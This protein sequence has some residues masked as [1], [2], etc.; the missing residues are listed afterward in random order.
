MI[1]SSST[2]GTTGDKSSTKKLGSIQN[3]DNH[4]I[5]HSGNGPSQLPGSSNLLSSFLPSNNTNG[6]KNS[7]PNDSIA[8]ENLIE[9]NYNPNIKNYP[10]SQRN[11][12][13]QAAK[14]EAQNVISSLKDMQDH[15]DIRRNGHSQHYKQMAKRSSIKNSQS[16]SNEKNDRY[17][18]ML[19]NFNLLGVVTTPRILEQIAAGKANNDVMDYVHNVNGTGNDTS[20]LSTGTESSISSFIDPSFFSS[21][22]AMSNTLSKEIG[23]LNSTLYSYSKSYLGTM[24]YSGNGAVEGFSVNSLSS[25]SGNLDF[26]AELSA[27]TANSSSGGV[28]PYVFGEDMLKGQIPN[29]ELP[30]EIT[31]LDLSSVEAYLRKCGA[32]AERLNLS[33]IESNGSDD[34]KQDNA[35]NEQGK[36]VEQ[37]E[38][39]L[40]PTKGVPEIF[41]SQYF[42]L[43]DPEAFSSLLVLQDTDDDELENDDIIK[44]Q[45]PTDFTQYLD[46]IEL[47]LLHQ[48]RTKSS[49]F[50]RETNR[51]THLKSL[52]ASSVQDVQSL[53]HDLDQIRERSIL[54]AEMVPLMD[55]R[56]KDTQML[57]KVLDEIEN[58]V[59]VK[60]SVGNLIQDGQYLE[61][62]ER[63]NLARSLLN[64]E[65][66]DPNEKKTERHVLK[67]IT[68]LNKIHE[69]L[70]QYEN[71]VVSGNL[72]FY[73]YL[74]F[75]Y[76]CLTNTVSIGHGSFERTG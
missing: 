17:G 7:H 52:V 50:F 54:D 55:R 39:E 57:K 18:Q 70:A 74:P 73:K 22:S 37:E 33:N 69:Q 56:R 2:N 13:R 36:S 24:P 38:N 43:T 20:A 34:E 42:D 64:G 14:D 15:G 62:V 11:I 32:V 63:I 10:I 48:V 66:S 41:F 3:K 46:S 76:F 6:S 27:I 51:F 21:M 28:Y 53:R 4:E 58:V 12:S 19:D 35:K 23:S 71:L 25:M 8:K 40:D 65:C 30:P 9:E 5:S 61:A 16:V 72:L 29:E 26:E 59:E 60:T 49:S 68:A 47:A 31:D 1:T 45:D 67:K 44:I 75:T